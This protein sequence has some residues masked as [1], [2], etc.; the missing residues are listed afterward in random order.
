MKELLKASVVVIRELVI[1][2]IKLPRLLWN[3]GTSYLILTLSPAAFKLRKIARQNKRNEQDYTRKCAERKRDRLLN[4]S[5]YRGR[6]DE[7]VYD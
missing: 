5:K 7:D 6:D 4:P 1:F 3:L 2:A